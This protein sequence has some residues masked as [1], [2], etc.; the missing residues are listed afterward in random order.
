MQDDMLNGETGQRHEKSYVIFERKA[1]KQRADKLT[2]LLIS[3]RVLYLNTFAQ[4][5]FETW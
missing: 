3:F 4:L 1:N 2:K 5:E